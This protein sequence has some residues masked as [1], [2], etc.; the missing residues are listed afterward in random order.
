MIWKKSAP[1]NRL[2]RSRFNAFGWAA[3]W[4]GFSNL[5]FAIVLAIA[6]NN[7]LTSH[8]MD[9]FRPKLW[10]SATPVPVALDKVNAD[11]VSHDSPY[12][13]QSK[14]S[15]NI[16]RVPISRSTFTQAMSARSEVKSDQ[17]AD[18][19]AYHLTDGKEGEIVNGPETPANNIDAVIDG[20]DLA[21][22]VGL[23]NQPNG[24]LVSPI[25]VK[26]A[27]NG[28]LS[29]GNFKSFSVAGS[30]DECLSVARTMLQDVG[31]STDRLSIVTASKQI[32]IAKICASNGAVVISCRGQ[33]I[34]MSPRRSRPDDNCP[35]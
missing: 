19:A 3:F 35:A 29:I 11:L 21:S 24:Q 22:D 16:T 25:L 31:I 18:E 8:Y 33:H 1:N 12:D 17:V 27:V 26:N 2:P 6:A 20:N 5:V 34:T 10:D 30:S 7:N 14:G 23:A 13:P 9:L 15:L 28:Q 32:T 4:I